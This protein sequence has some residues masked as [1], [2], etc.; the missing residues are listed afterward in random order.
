MRNDH[1]DC[2]PEDRQVRIELE[3][4]RQNECKGQSFAEK[5]DVHTLSPF[6]QVYQFG[7]HSNDVFRNATKHSLN[8]LFKKDSIMHRVINYSAEEVIVAI[9]HSSTNVS[10]T[11]SQ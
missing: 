1:N 6:S 5:P 8:S 7:E 9:G 11:M 4:I 3:S 2:T 10:P